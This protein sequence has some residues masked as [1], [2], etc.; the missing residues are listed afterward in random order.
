MDERLL[1]I[2]DLYVEYITDDAQVFAVNG[3]DLS[4]NRAKPLAWW[5]RPGRGK[6]QPH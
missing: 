2:K 5:G 1:E 6:P 3:I 4:L